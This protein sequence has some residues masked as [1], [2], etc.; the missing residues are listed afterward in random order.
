MKNYWM[1]RKKSVGFPVDDEFSLICNDGGT[2]NLDIYYNCQ[3]V[4]NE[5][6]Q[7]IN[8]EQHGYTIYQTTYTPIYAGSMSGYIYQGDFVKYTFYVSENGVFNFKRVD[9]WGKPLAENN[10]YL[11]TYYV[12]GGKLNLATGELTLHWA[13]TLAPKVIANYE[14]NL[15]QI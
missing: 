8:S 11:Y 1:D 2:V 6:L 12:D 4:Q 14:Y 15:G 3:F 9:V 13:G 7:V 5:E 10:E